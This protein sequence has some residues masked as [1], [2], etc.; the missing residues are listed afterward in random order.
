LQALAL[1]LLVVAPDVGGI[2]EAVTSDTGFLVENVADE[3]GLVDAIVRAVAQASDADAD[4]QRRAIREAGRALI[5]RR[6]TR[7]VFLARLSELLRLNGETGA[8][9]QHVGASPRP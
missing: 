3:P 4:P 1:G 5:G 6:H 2:R 9:V 8:P 7:D